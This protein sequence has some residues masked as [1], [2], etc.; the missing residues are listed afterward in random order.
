MCVDYRMLNKITIKN[1]YPLP[2]IDEM[3]DRLHGARFFTKVDLASGYHQIRIKEE[4]IPK[5]AFRTRYGHYEFTVMPFGLCN[6]PATFQR[7]MNDVFR[8]QLD[9][10]VIVYL[11]DILIYSRTWEEHKNHVRQ[12]LEIL[13]QHK[14]YAKRSK[15]TFV[16]Q[17]VDFLGYIVSKDGIATDPK[18]LEAVQN[19]PVPRTVH[20]VRSFMGLA[21]YY[22]RFVRHF[23][24]IAAPL[25]ALMS[26]KLA[27]KGGLLP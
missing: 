24:T 18:K 13:R 4:D 19:W 20:D 2:R 16:V 14:L 15:C 27:Q 22:R 23:S 21:N 26:R 5:T 11:D 1:R 12:V 6:A 17:E 9:R 8:E 7:L 10:F 3:L 25:T